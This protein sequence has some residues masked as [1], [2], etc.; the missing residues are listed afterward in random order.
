[1]SKRTLF[2]IVMS[3]AYA[4][5]VLGHAFWGGHEK[6]LFK[7]EL[8]NFGDFLAGLAAPLAFLWLVVGYLQQGEELRLQRQQ[9]ELQREELKLQREEVKRLADE[10]GRQAVAVEANELHAR[11]DT[12]F[13]QA[14]FTMEELK[15]LGMA[16]FEKT[17]KAPWAFGIDAV[18]NDF[19]GG[20]VHKYY[21]LILVM[22][23]EN[24][25]AYRQHLTQEIVASN[26]DRYFKLC[27]ELILSADRADPDRTLRFLYRGTMALRVYEA[28]CELLGRVSIFD[29]YP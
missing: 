8:N 15:A 1:M 20:N 16:I 28:F 24:R 7:L 25:D 2:A 11:R 22:I 4:A 9:L 19:I 12:F 29:L 27:E 21:E 17:A 26:L 10:A 13:R 14:D 3:V 5:L 18:R 23:R 6:G